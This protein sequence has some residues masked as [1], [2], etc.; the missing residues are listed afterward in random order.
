MK[1]ID[2]YIEITMSIC[3]LSRTGLI[4]E[5]LKALQYVSI[6]EQNTCYVC[7][8]ETKRSESHI[9]QGISLI[10]VTSQPRQVR[11]RFT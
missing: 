1:C 11:L 8:S 7:S 4:K 10:T 9:Q 3:S 5:K 2:K 6:M